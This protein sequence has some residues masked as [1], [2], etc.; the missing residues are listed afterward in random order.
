MSVADWHRD[1]GVRSCNLLLVDIHTAKTRWVAYA[2]SSLRE[3]A[4]S[5]TRTIN[6]AVVEV[7]G[8]ARAVGIHHVPL[9]CLQELAL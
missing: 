3:L 4:P 2:T 8:S 7:P 5:A 9:R 6:V 1:Q